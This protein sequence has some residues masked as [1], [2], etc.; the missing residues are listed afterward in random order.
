VQNLPVLVVGAV[1]DK[2]LFLIEGLG[3]PVTA[4]QGAR[5]ATGMWGEVTVSIRGDPVVALAPPQFFLKMFM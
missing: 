3:W 5:E 1:Y 2:I 4:D